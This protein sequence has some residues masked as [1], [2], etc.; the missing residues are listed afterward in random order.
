MGIEVPCGGPFS[1]EEIF[2]H[3]E[4]KKNWLTQ[5]KQAKI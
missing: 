2:T 3:T 5:I 4:K 1:A